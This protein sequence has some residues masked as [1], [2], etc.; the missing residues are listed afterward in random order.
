ME[1]IS[2]GAAAIIGGGSLLSGLISSFF[3]SQA[4]DEAT[5]AAKEAQNQNYQLAMQERADNKERFS[6]Q[7]AME[8]MKMKLFKENQE[9]TQENADEEKQ[10]S[11]AMGFANRLVSFGNS[12]NE[13]GK[14]LAS[15]WAQQSKL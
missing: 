6:I 15:T 5:S 1:P 10:A 12:G 11:R 7:Q 9:W 4:A 13:R 14:G 2:L 3:N 8:N